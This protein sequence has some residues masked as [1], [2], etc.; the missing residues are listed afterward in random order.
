MLRFMNKSRIGWKLEKTEKPVETERRIYVDDGGHLY[1]EA[2]ELLL[3]PDF[4]R[5]L[6]E[7]DTLAEQLGLKKRSQDSKKTT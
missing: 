5:Q 4:K 7:A 3:D 2:E 1:V 6:K